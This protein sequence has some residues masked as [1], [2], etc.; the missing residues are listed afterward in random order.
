MTRWI[1]AA[2]LG[3]LSVLALGALSVPAAQADVLSILPG[4]C[5]SAEASQP[6][7]QFGDGNYYVLV[8]G[9][10]FQGTPWQL[11]G[12]ATVVDGSLSLPA[13][14]S[15][16]SPSTCTSIYDPTLRLFV[17]NTGSSASRLTVQALV[18]GLLGGTD[19]TTVG[20]LTGTSSWEPSPTMTLL[21]SNLLSTLSLGSTNI[22]FRFTPADN[23]GA[24]SINDVYQDPFMRH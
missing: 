10:N 2:G 5:G 22:A 23:K 7:A 4:S 3:A 12:G 20:E 18:P 13:G 24:W 11:S 19:T 9:G 8:P 15:A 1:R 21:L 14:S 17:R 16:T 6:F